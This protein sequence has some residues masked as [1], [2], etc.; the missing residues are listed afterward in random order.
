M[1]A[2]IHVPESW[3]NRLGTDKTAQVVVNGTSYSGKVLAV[4]LEPAKGDSSASSY[5]VDV[6][7]ELKD[8]LLR[9]GQQ[10]SVIIE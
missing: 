8:Q 2:R 4:G 9:A 7:F 6:Q 3:L 1:L 10:A 5:P